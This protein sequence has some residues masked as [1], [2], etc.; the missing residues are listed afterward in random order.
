MGSWVWRR[1]LKHREEF[2]TH[3]SM[4]ENACWDDVPYDRIKL[5]VIWNSIRLVRPKVEWYDLVWGTGC[6]PRNSFFWLAVRFGTSFY[7]RPASQM[8]DCC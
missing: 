1:I 2:L 8:G 3:F 6:R 4:E 7:Q 5:S